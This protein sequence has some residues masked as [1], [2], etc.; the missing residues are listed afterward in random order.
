MGADI[1]TPLDVSVPRLP[2]HVDTITKAPKTRDYVFDLEAGNS[3]QEEQL[4]PLTVVDEDFYSALEAINNEREELFGIA[5]ERESELPEL[6]D[7]VLAQ[8]VSELGITGFAEKVCRIL[9]K[10]GYSFVGNGELMHLKSGNVV[11]F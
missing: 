4:K 11:R 2:L 9:K 5:Q 7:D 10:N 8:Y 3:E 6:T 1:K